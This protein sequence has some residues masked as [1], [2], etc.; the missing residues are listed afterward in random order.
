[1]GPAGRGVVSEA[2]SNE[3]LE[4]STTSPARGG[5][6]GPKSRASVR[7]VLEKVFK[8]LR[9]S[10]ER[11]PEYG[12]GAPSGPEKTIWSESGEAGC[13]QVPIFAIENRPRQ[14]CGRDQSRDFRREG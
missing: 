10:A 8:T 7:D 13:A 14:G 9:E 3:K 4:F 1:M 6:S 5:E 2:K 11:G 12:E